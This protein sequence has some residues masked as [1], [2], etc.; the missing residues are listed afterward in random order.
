MPLAGRHERLV[1]KAEV[2]AVDV[3]DG[4]RTKLLMVFVRAVW[5]AFRIFVV[6]H[7]LRRQGKD[8]AQ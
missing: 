5:R 3:F 8:W 1:L 4:V 2:H 6:G 7:R